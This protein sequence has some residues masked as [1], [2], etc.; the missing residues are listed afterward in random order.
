MSLLPKLRKAKPA[1]GPLSLAAVETMPP[2]QIMARLRDIMAGS[3]GSGEKLDNIVRLVAPALRADVCSCY[4]MR[5]GEVLELFATI[6]LNPAAVHQTRL[7]VGEGLVGEIAARAAPMAVLD[8]PA[9]PSFVYRPE[10]DEDPYSSFCGVPILRGRR[11]RGVL[12]IQNRQP[13]QYGTE[14][15]ETLQTIAMVMAELIASGDLVGRS[16]VEP[17]VADTNFIRPSHINGASLSRGLA[18]GQAVLHLPLLS[19]HEIVSDD[20]EGERRRLRGA[21]L[22]MH[23]AID[24]ILDAPGAVSQE[25]SRDILETYRMFAHDRGWISRIDEAIGQGLTAEAAVQRVQDENRA[26]MLQVN[27]PYIRERVQDLEDLSNR[28]LTHLAGKDAHQMNADSLPDNIILV[29]RSLGPA[30]LLE[31][32][33]ARLRGVILESGTENNHV[34]IIARALRIPMIGQCADVL[35]YIE[36]GEPVIVDGDSGTCYIRPSDDVIDMYGRSMES[37]VQRQVL[38]RQSRDKAAV[39]LDNQYVSLQI[40]AGLTMEADCL[41][42]TGADGIGLFRTELSFLGRSRY[43]SVAL[44]SELYKRIMDMA[45]GKPVTFRTLDIGGDKPLPY[46]D[47]PQEENPALGWRAIRIGLDRPAIL[48]TQFRALIRAAQGRPL[49]IMLPLVADAHEIDTA[50]RLLDMEIARANRQS[51]TQGHGTPGSIELGI[52][53]EVPSLLWQLDLLVGSID[54]LSVGSNDLMQYLFAADRGNSALRLR[55]DT[56]SP[57]MLRAL[58][59]IADVCS[60]AQIPLNVCGEMAGQPLEAMA[61]VALGYRGLSMSPQSI[62]PVKAMLHSLDVGRLSPWLLKRM[63]SR[64]QSLRSD[65]VAFARDHGVCIEPLQ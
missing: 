46:F 10:T 56:L 6:G 47:A 64:E 24:R 65:L 1:S 44:Q 19:I 23:N 51:E 45:G 12:V 62:G 54:F 43:P 7:R 40:N 48:R 58:A 29:A 61:L 11:V 15:T 55:Y 59:Y 8:A 49:R 25:E 42:E 5:A 9:H 27:D 3:G 18:M 35:S 36:P 22:R 50:R 16:E 13:R 53:I 41:E 26:R 63:N 32:D 14:I 31:Y 20:P 4:V 39:T 57:P 21:V 28:L 33:H 38:F 37:R 30:A 52:M 17:T 60:R 2:G 34:A